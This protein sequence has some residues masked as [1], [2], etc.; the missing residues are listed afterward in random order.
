MT[1]HWAA[2]TDPGRVRGHNE[3]NLWPRPEGAGA[4]AGEAEAPFLAM[5]ADGMGGHVAG[6]VASRLAAEA[7][8]EAEGDPVERVSRAIL[9]AIEAPRP[10][11]RYPLTPLWCASR[12]LGD[13]M[14]GRLTKKAM[15]PRPHRM[16]MG[17]RGGS[18]FPTGWSAVLVIGRAGPSSLCL[19]LPAAACLAS[20]VHGIA[21]CDSGVQAGNGA[22]YL[23]EST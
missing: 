16:M 14:L 2:A 20:E 23:E 11:V 5:V 10:K 6:E 17:A 15:G 3:D 12:I 1:F 9:T 4:A 19:T 21:L 8:L 22:F 7:A 13:R 18:A